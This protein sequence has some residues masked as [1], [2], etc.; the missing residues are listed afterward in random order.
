M[1][2]VKNCYMR[3]PYGYPHYGVTNFQIIRNRLKYINCSVDYIYYI[4]TIS[5]KKFIIMPWLSLLKG[6]SKGALKLAV[7]KAAP[8][9]AKTVAKNALAGATQ[10]G[11]NHVMNSMLGGS[12]RRRR[13][14]RRR[15]CR[16]Y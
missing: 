2:K 11:T 12:G 4:K 1:E 6:L 14:R 9:I 15:R 5:S 10:Y 13:R 16:R 7:K 3:Y 8:K